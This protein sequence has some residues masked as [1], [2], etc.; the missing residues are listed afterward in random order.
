MKKPFLIVIDGPMGAGKTTVANLLQGRMHKDLGFTALISLD[1]LKRIVSEYKMDSKIHL[2]LASDI[3]ISMT[4]EYLKNNIDVIVEKAFTRAEFVDSFIRP[5]KKKARLFIYQ[6]E[7]PADIGAR[8]VRE[9]PLHPEIKKRPPKSKFERNI[10]HYSQFKYK[11][12]K[13]FDSNKLT[14]RQ[15]VNQIMKDIK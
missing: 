9:R 10:R 14:P 1:R 4:K 7:V 5:F 15:I 13:V 3:G 2:K 6:I 11:K 12:A 8:R